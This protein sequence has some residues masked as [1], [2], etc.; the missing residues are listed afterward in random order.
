M[1]AVKRLIH[2]LRQARAHF[3][4]VTVTDGLYQQVLEAGFLEHLAENVEDAAL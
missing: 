1:V 3:R 2:L 4:L